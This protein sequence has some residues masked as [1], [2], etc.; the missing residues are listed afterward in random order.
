LL[1]HPAD[2]KLV[3]G[4][5]S[6]P[7]GG[8]LK[9]TN[10]GLGWKV[11]ANS[12]FEGASLGSLAVHPSDPDIVYLSVWKGG[13]GG[14]GVYKSVDGGLT[15]KNTTA[16]HLGGASDVIV[17]R[18]DPQML[19]AGLI[20]S[21]NT[22]STDGVYRSSDGGAS[23]HLLGGL[24]SSYFAGESAL[25]SAARFDSA[26]TDGW[27]YVTLFALD[28]V[29]AATVERY[30]TSDRGDTWSKLAPTPGKM[31]DRRWHLVLA[32]HRENPEHVFVND[33]YELY[34]STDAGKT[35]TR[36]DIVGKDGIGDDWVD[37]SFGPGNAIVATG[38][39]NAYRCELETRDGA[40]AP[41]TCS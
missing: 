40:S 20:D 8:I 39:R 6:G 28:K 37:V 36:A 23:W 33:A 7:G 11:L 2:H 27:V 12:Q 4:A 19:Y 34:E 9:S 31:E 18:F 13:V 15:W 16:S 41:A 21:S 22:F 17:A 25:G 5:V 32:V 26:F 10:G 14:G 3:L 29:G 30:R 24:P 38:D 35:W 1:V